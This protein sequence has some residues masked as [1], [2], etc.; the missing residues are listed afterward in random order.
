[1]VSL[2]FNSTTAAVQPRE[3]LVGRMLASF[4]KAFNNDD[5][6]TPVLPRTPIVVFG[7]PFSLIS[8]IS[9]DHINC[10]AVVVTLSSSTISF[11]WSKISMHLF[12]LF[13]ATST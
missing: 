7:N 10:L 11:N 3:P 1:M 13:F 9:F 4:N 2:Y 12:V 8:L 5:F 6:P